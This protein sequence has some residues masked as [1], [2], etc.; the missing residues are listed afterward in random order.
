MSGM[1]PRNYPDRPLLIDSLDGVNDS[2][3][4]MK[5]ELNAMV[6]SVAV[7][8][9]VASS[10]AIVRSIRE[11]KQIE[12]KGIE[13]CVWRR[14]P[15]PALASFVSSHLL[16]ET[17]DLRATG[18]AGVTTVDRLLEGLPNYDSR[19]LLRDDIVNLAEA[20]AEAVK[21]RCLDFRLE[22]IDDDM[23]RRFHVD[24]YT[25]RLL[26]TYAGPAT[27][28]IENADVIRERLG[29]QGR[30]FPHPDTN[31]I[32][33]N[34]RIRRLRT[35]DVAILK[36]DLW[37]DGESLGAVHRSPPIKRRKAK[38]LLLKIDVL[39]RPSRKNQPRG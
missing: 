11:L 36:G 14:R 31:M 8:Q 35:F 24:H 38:R 15:D 12:R 25:C 28:W 3:F 22:R 32:R 30:N 29:S 4:S 39:R 16:D 21:V 17:F 27:Q 1:S 23:C 13:L 34:G 33:P 18:S 7:D 9:S 10:A 20:F 19:I 26:C 37:N 5:R 2:N 6:T